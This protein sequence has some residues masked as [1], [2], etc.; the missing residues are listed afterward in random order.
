MVVLTGADSFG[1]DMGKLK[2]GTELGRK[3]MRGSWNARPYGPLYDAQIQ[4]VKNGTDH[5]FNKSKFLV[6][7]DD[8]HY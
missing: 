5:Y 1:S 3:L 7:R 6:K 8:R 4:G 2:D